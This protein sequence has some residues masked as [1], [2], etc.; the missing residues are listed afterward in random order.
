MATPK[1]LLI[2]WVLRTASS[3]S[4]WFQRHIQTLETSPDQKTLFTAIGLTPRKLGKADIALTEEDFHA[5]DSLVPGWDPTEYSVDMAARLALVLTAFRPDDDFYTTF[6]T[7]WRTADV[8]EQVALYRGLC[9][10]PEPDRV[11]WQAE[12]GCRTNIKGV[13][14]AIAHRNPFP[15]QHFDDI[16]FNQLCLKALFVGAS[17]HLIQRLDERSNPALARMMTDYAFER[18]AASRTVS[19]ELWRCV[20]PHPDARCLKALDL[21]LKATDELTRLGAT[22]ACSE[23]QHPEARRLL[24]SHPQAAAKNQDANAHWAALATRFAA[25]TAG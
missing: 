9:L 2:D 16:A 5:A 1:G 12:E 20:A 15:A 8:G 18:W 23:S 10:Y 19:P 4:A 24:A 6:D 22:L 7:I 21:A 13:F 11:R 25:S 3:G 14:E 17:L